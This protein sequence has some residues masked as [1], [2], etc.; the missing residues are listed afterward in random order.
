MTAMSE[1]KENFGS[2]RRHFWEWPIAT[3][4]FLGGL[5]GGIFCLTAIL[6]FFVYPEAFNTIGYVMAW[7]VFLGIL[8]LGF[9]CFLLV[10]ELGQPFVFL[11]VFLNSTS[12]ICWGA[13]ILSVCLIFGFVWFLSYIPESTPIVG[14]LLAPLAELLVPFRGLCLG[15]AGISGTCIMLY[16]GILLS[17]LKAHSFWATPALPVL[18]TVSALSTACACIT[19]SVGWWPVD[20]SF[21]NEGIVQQ[22]MMSG[23]A[24]AYEAYLTYAAAHEISHL[25][26]TVDIILAAC[27]IVVLLVMTLS[28]LGA[29]NVT[30]NRAAKRWVIGSWKFLFWGGMIC[31]GLVIPELLYVFADGF[32]NEVLAPALVLCGGLLLRFMVVY[33]D[34]RAPLPGEKLY[35]GK[36]ASNDALFLTRWTYGKNEF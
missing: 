17:S 30:A 21:M 36:L 1:T 10:F 8:C 12:I 14:G 4:L 23:D 6:S 34:D 27:E 31:C 19:L 9:G 2:V 26:H 13:R 18:F 11:R 24:V 7:P 35:Y 28:F 25:L 20:Q 32:A 3:Y 33:S 5:G 22:L 29:G 16:T 15:L